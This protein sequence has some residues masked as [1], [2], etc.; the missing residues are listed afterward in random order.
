MEQ[1]IPSTYSTDISH[2]VSNDI[3]YTAMPVQ[4]TMA[5]D[6]VFQYF[7]QEHQNT[8]NELFPSQVNFRPSSPDQK[9]G[10]VLRK[11]CEAASDCM[12]EDLLT[13]EDFFDGSSTFLHYVAAKGRVDD[14]MEDILGFCRHHGHPIDDDRSATCSTALHIA[15][16]HDR[17]KNVMLLADAGARTDKIDE[18]DTPGELPLHVAIRIS[19]TP[20]LVAYLL[21]RN[22]RAASQRVQ[23]PSEREGQVAVDL[24]IGRL[25]HDLAHS[26]KRD[27]TKF[28][29]PVLQEV[30]A[31]LKGTQVLKDT[32]HLRA[33]ARQDSDLFLRAIFKVKML[34]N[35]KNLQ[36][37]MEAVLGETQREKQGPGFL[38]DL[39]LMSRYASLDSSMV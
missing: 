24:A 21:Q 22:K 13:E 34:A 5:M 17:F 26:D 39:E 23:K 28:S 1:P 29:A 12:P 7:G 9:F 16:R 30:L 4:Q 18:T 6:N 33:H 8:L 15:V 35:S 25:L 2:L 11:V 19:K 37:I 27:S 10:Q 38:C 3:N 32:Q 36:Q 20:Q 31:S 14:V